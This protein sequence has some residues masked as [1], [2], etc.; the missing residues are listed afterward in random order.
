MVTADVWAAAGMPKPTVRA[1]NESDS[2]FLFVGCIEKRLA[3]TLLA[4]ALIKT[5][6]NEPSPRDTPRLASR[7]AA[8]F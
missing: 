6:I 8:P 4:S 7:R 1:F 5:P 3:R 2:D